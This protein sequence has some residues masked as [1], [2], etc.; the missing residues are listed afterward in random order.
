MTKTNKSGFQNANRRQAPRLKAST[1][2][3]LKSIALNQGSEVEA[4]DI[5]RGG[6]LI[7]TDARI[8][9]QTKILIKLVTSGGVICM[10]GHVLRSSVVSLDNGPKYRT[11]ISFEN[12]L[13]LA[14]TPGSNSGEQPRDSES[15][16][17]ARFDEEHHADPGNN[18]DQDPAILTVIANDKYDVSLYQYLAHNRG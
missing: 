2:P 8:R 6:M 14:H 13:H 3:F 18:G 5:S 16:A 9:P 12:P 4:I 1:L 15:S 7:E 11:A 17:S 10:A